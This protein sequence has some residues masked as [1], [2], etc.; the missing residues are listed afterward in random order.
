METKGKYIAVMLLGLL[1]ASCN[2]KYNRMLTVINE[3]GTCSREYSF[4]T[5]QSRLAIPQDE[6]F[7]SLID[8]SWERTWSI[9]DSDT[10]DLSAQG[11]LPE[12]HPVPLTETQFDSIQ[13]QDMSKSLQGLL[14]A[15]IKKDFET[16]QDMSNCLYQTDDTHGTHLVKA[17]GFKAKSKLEK[18]FKWF[19]TDY[20]FSETFTF[21]RPD[22][23]PI[24]ISRF[25]S[26]D[27][28][29]FWLTG[30]PD[31]TQHYHSGAELKQ[32]LDGIEGK[33]SQW[34]NANWFTEICNYIVR[35][36]DKI[37]NPPLDKEQFINLFDS[38][39][40]KPI[41]LNIPEG[42]TSTERFKILDDYSHSNAYSKFLQSNPSGPDLP[43]G[44]ELL[45]SFNTMYDLMMPGRVTDSGIGEYDGQVI[46][47]RI[48]GDRFIS[49]D[50]TLTFA[51]T[52]RV[53]NIW[54]F[55]VTFF[56]IVIAI[57]SFFYRKK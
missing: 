25:L 7:D 2:N 54:A 18:H 35:N 11:N 3:D 47:Y 15:H 51:A 43:K 38:L 6:D 27:T 29:S 32:M 16:V 26:A 48:T 20:A 52:S 56:I 17:E 12:R 34:F 21:D 8:K 1:M 49:D 50:H 19:Y 31:L 41:V 33:L 9:L 42:E 23:F 37:E 57:G 10:A 39:A 28:V 55:I 45:M 30:K 36:Y 46:H 44:Y 14:M 13:K 24:P 53:T 5:T 22:V 40:M 4:R